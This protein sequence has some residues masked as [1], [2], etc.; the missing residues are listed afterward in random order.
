MEK[1]I[2]V[3][4]SVGIRKSESEVDNADD[5]YDGGDSEVGSVVDGEKDESGTESEN[6]DKNSEIDSENCN[7]SGDESGVDSENRDNN[8][9]NDSESR[10]VDRNTYPL[11]VLKKRKRI[12]RGGE[13][14]Q[15]GR[16]IGGLLRM[17]KSCL[18]QC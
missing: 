8:S 16:G 11:Q 13:R 14:F 12:F 1:K 5:G 4:A 6:R 9:E 18:N 7:E 3:D 10:N 15:R 2:F 17:V